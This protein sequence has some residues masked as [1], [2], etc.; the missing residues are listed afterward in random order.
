VS[1]DRHK[2][3][4]FGKL[5]DKVK[6]D[7]ELRTPV[8]RLGLSLIKKMN[9]APV[10][11]FRIVFAFNEKDKQISIVFRLGEENLFVSIVFAFREKPKAFVVFR[12][13]LAFYFVNQ[14]VGIIFTLGDK[15]FYIC[16]VFTVA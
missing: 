16:I 3:C 8:I 11:P 1:G 13:I 9:L 6:P 4:S 10:P 12:I 2:S 7:I 5:G 15:N 14:Q